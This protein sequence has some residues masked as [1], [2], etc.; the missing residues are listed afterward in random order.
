MDIHSY[1]IGYLEWLTL[2]TMN[3]KV[4][5]DNNS[6]QQEVCYRQNIWIQIFRKAGRRWQSK[7]QVCR[8]G[9]TIR[10]TRKDAQWLE[11]LK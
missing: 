2:N 8:S 3:V 5:A 7:C 11:L 4:N 10:S 1:G 6:F 9:E